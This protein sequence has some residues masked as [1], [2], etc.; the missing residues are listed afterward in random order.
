MLARKKRLIKMDDQLSLQPFV[1][2]GIQDVAITDH[3]IGVAQNRFQYNFADED[4][5]IP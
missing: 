4:F 5:P 1:E 3:V 2:V